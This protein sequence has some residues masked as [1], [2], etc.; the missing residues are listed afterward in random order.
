MDSSDM[1]APPTSTANPNPKRSSWITDSASV[2]LV[3]GS[4][5]LGTHMI[6]SQ[7]VS[8]ANGQPAS[9]Q[10]S[11]TYSPAR[12]HAHTHTQHA[13]GR[14]LSLLL[15]HYSSGQ[16]LTTKT[17]RGCVPWHRSLCVVVCR[18]LQRNE[19]NGRKN[20]QIERQ[21][22]QHD[23]REIDF[24]AFTQLVTCSDD[25]YAVVSLRVC[26]TWVLCSFFGL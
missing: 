25:S 3:C 21:R 2:F 1:K 19:Q 17:L 7:A 23:A 11:W 22:G 5:L 10:V 6:L 13:V 16:P 8:Q 4:D 14:T 24:Y 9:Q 20:I 18:K 15:K 26:R 12:T